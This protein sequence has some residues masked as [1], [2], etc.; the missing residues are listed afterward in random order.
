MARD[1]GF[2]PKES[3]A[4]PV[5]LKYIMDLLEQTQS[6]RDQDAAT[7]ATNIQL[8]DQANQNNYDA[9]SLQ[10]LE[11]LIEQYINQGE[12]H[13]SL[14]GDKTYEILGKQYSSNIRNRKDIA[15]NAENSLNQVGNYMANELNNKFN[16]NFFKGE[17]G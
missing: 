6:R 17:D 5:G 16:P 3:T 2:G 12:N 13:T 14:T 8:L 9:S 15:S 1:Y 4:I 7:W 11:P 10:E